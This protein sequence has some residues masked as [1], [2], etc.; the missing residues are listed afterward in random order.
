MKT[1][2]FPDIRICRAVNGVM[3]ME[4]LQS[5]Q[6]VSSTNGTHV[7]ND[8]SALVEHLKSVIMDKDQ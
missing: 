5:N 2:D 7:F 8:F 4:G 3:V 6:M 1:K